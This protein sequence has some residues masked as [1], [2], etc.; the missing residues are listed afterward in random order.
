MKGGFINEFPADLVDKLIDGFEGDPSRNT[1]LYFQHS[2]GAIGRVAADSTAFAH[3][4]S[5]ANALI[6]VSW[7]L[8]T[9]SSPHVDY[10]RRYWKSVESYSDGWYTNGVSDEPERVLHANYQ[11]NFKR[12]LQVKNQYDPSNLFRLNANIKPTV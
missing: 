6:F 11:G 3:R 4:K 1:T 10:I 7:P 8:G 2:G 12:L 9:D 5:A